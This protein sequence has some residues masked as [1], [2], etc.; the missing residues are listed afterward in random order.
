MNALTIPTRGVVF[1]L[2]KLST[3]ED[4]EDTEVKT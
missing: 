3:T 2:A 4:T 1:K